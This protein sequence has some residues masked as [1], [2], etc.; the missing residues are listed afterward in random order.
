VADRPAKLTFPAVEPGLRDIMAGGIRVGFATAD[1]HYQW[2]ARLFATAGEPYAGY[3][4]TVTR[5]GL[6]ELRQELGRKLSNE[7]NWWEPGEGSAPL[8]ESGT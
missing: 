1:F 2:T 7:G 5:K 4:G 3:A 6:Q 8:P